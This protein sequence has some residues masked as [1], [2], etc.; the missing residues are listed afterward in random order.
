MEQKTYTNIADALGIERVPDP[1]N[2]S[3]WFTH[4]DHETRRGKIHPK[5]SNSAYMAKSFYSIV[6]IQENVKG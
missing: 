5:G 1:K 3:D 6:N 4:E 2:E